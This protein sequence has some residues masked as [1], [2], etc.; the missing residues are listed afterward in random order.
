MA[1][2]YVLASMSAVALYYALPGAFWLKLLAADILATVI[3]F[4]FSLLFKNASVYD[5]YWSVQ[6]MIIV[7]G[8]EMANKTTFAGVLMVIVILLWGLRLTANW[9]YTFKGLNYQD[10]RYTMLEEKTGKNYMLVNF[11]GI[12]LV[13]TLI[14]YL[15]VLP[16][17]CLIES[18]AKANIGIVLFF[19]VSLGAVV[20]QGVA[21]YQM[22]M[23]RRHRTGNFIRT[24]LWEYSRHPNY[25]GEILMWWGVAL[26]AVCS[27]PGKFFLIIGA[28]ANTCLFL[29]VSIPM[30]EQRQAKKYGFEQYKKETRLLLPIK[31]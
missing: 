21:D 15:C 14:V 10:W 28:I 22:H 3:T 26:S 16:A 2:V 11:V 23:Y 30:A 12:H 9:A 1:I 4:A 7:L 25:L 20:L 17:V 31:K 13:P 6:P 8:F 29:F 27:M 24:G 19:L 18:G 5:P